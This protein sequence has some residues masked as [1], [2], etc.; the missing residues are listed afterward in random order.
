M[1]T[2]RSL[3]ARGAGELLRDDLEH[4]HGFSVWAVIGGVGFETA[5]HVDYAEMYR[6]ETNV[7]RPP[8]HALT[9]QV[10]PLPEGLEPGAVVGG[11]FGAHVDGLEHYRRTGYKTRKCPVTEGDTPTADWG[12]DAGWQFAPYRF[13]QATICSGELP[14]AADKV[15]A[16]PTDLQR[17]VIGINSMGHLEGPI[18]MRV[19]QHSKAFKRALQLELLTKRLGGPEQVAMKLLEMHKRKLQAQQAGSTQA[20]PPTS[21]Q[22]AKT[23]HLGEQEAPQ[24]GTEQKPPPP[25]TEPTPPSPSPPP[26]PPPPPS[27]APKVEINGEE[28]RDPQTVS[29]APVMACKG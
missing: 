6:R 10:S 7:I 5:Y 25:P 1:S 14:H 29:P 16:W 11:T 26:P 15:K 13:N 3:F 23:E 19:P 12:S 8:V 28:Q 22:V 9:L 4:V 24:P 27:S 17:V 20:P 2:L 21:N 18:E